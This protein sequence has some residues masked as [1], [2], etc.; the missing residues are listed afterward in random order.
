MTVLDNGADVPVR[1]YRDDSGLEADAI[2]ESRMERM[3]FLFER[4]GRRVVGHKINQCV[5]K[6]ATDIIGL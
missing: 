5:S 6:W 3:P 2:V 4:C 1:Y